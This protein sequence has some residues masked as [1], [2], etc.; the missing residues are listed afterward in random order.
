MSYSLSAVAPYY[1]LDIQCFRMNWIILTY[2][3]V[4]RVIVS[5]S[6]LTILQAKGCVDV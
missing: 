6:N 3:R 1:V 5:L 2:T 4:S